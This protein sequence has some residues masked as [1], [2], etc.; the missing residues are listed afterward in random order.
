MEALKP[1]PFCGGNAV[2][3][4]KSN[5]STHYSAGFSFEVE[6]ED[7]GMKLPER[8][9]LN[10]SLTEEGEISVLNDKRPEAIKKWNHRNGTN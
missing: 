9:E 6:C 5:N 7:C 2:F 1:C 4:T 3:H 8:Y 10:L